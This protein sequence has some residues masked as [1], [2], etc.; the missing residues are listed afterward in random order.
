[1][2]NL[3][4]IRDLCKNKGISIKKLGEEIGI[5]TPQG[6]QRLINEN[7]TTIER[8]ESIAKILEVPVIVFF[9]DAALKRLNDRIKELEDYIQEFQKIHMLTIDSNDEKQRYINHLTEGNKKNHEIIETLRSLVAAQ[10]K[11]IT[12]LE[13]NI[14][15]YEKVIYPEN[16]EGTSDNKLPE[17]G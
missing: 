9:E 1:M 17:K 7:S 12:Q 11:Q 4:I 6:M 15:L 5:K 13:K 2:A 16:K 10:K 14:V 3:S 8:L